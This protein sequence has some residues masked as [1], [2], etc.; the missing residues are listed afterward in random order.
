MPGFEEERVCR[1]PAEEVW[2]LLY[3][4]ERFADW[5]DG[6]ARAEQGADGSV[7]RYMAAWPD[8][9]YPTNISSA[10]AGQ[11]IVISC[12]LSDI[13]HEWSLAPHVEGCLVRARIEIPEAEAARLPMI[14]G[15]TSRSID[16]LVACAERG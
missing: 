3:D 12:Q 5:W 14:H 11:R 15:E 6:M 13:E 16:N 10:K 7:N 1:A 2:K 9:A 4:P 8:F